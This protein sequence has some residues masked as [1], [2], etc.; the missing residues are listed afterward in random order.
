MAKVD[1]ANSDKET[2]ES[3]LGSFNVKEYLHLLWVNK[4][5]IVLSLVICV[6][7]AYYDFMRQARIYGSQAEVMLLFGNAG[8]ST[9]GGSGIQQLADMAGA[10][11]GQNVNMFNEMEII[12]SPML[13]QT[14]VQALGLNTTY[15]KEGFGHNEDLYG[16]TP[17]IVDF[18]DVPSTGS[19]S[20]TLRPGTDGYVVAS[21][22]A[23]D[24]QSKAGRQLNIPL[25]T[26]VNTP[27]GRI[28]VTPT[29]R[30]ASFTEP[31]H[32]VKRPVEE[33]ALGMSQRVTTEKK[34]IENSVVI[35]GFTDVNQ[36]RATAVVNGLV[37]AYRN[38]WAVEQSRQSEKSTEFIKERLAVI[39]KELSGID[40]N[41]SQVK[42]NAGVPDVMSA[43]GNFYGQAMSYDT[44][45][46]ES[47]T[48]LNIA[49]FLREYLEKHKGES[50]LIPSNTGANGTIEGQVAE[51][52][53]LVMKRN[54]LLANSSESNPVIAQL[55][56]DIA[57]ARSLI[58]ASLNNLIK[59]AQYE[60][61][62]AQGRGHDFSNRVAQ[63][64][65]SE[66][67]IISIERQQKVK[68]D[69]Y[70][71][72]L[73]KREE[74][75]LSSMI[76][77]DNTR[78]IRNGYETGLVTGAMRKALFAGV[79]VGLLIPLLIIFLGMQLNA[80]VTR[81]SELKDLSIPFLGEMPLTPSKR[82]R[83]F[84]LARVLHPNSRK[85]DDRELEIVVKPRSRSYINEA[86]RLIRTN[87][88]FMADTDKGSKVIMLTSFNPGSGK[89]FI[90]LNLA[91]SLALKGKKV[92][93]MDIDL[94]RA[95]LTRFAGNA[96]QGLSTYLTEK[97][98][99][100]DALIKPNNEGTGIDLLPVGAVPPNP[101]ELLLTERL[102]HLVAELR[103]KYDYIVLDCPPYDLVADTVIL[104]RVAD[105]TIFV[106][107]AGL[108]AKSMVPELE[109]IYQAGKLPRMSIILN[110]IDPRKSYYADRYGYKG[111][112]SYY[113]SED[114]DR[115]MKNELP[116]EEA[117]K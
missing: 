21:D 77:V 81:K 103:K 71:Y 106:I 109:K 4:F 74:N 94:R 84:S 36:E 43:A 8:S 60:V 52:N 58:M 14:V 49:K 25:G 31:I 105:M 10:G 7:Y 6:G 70:I 88:D 97:T 33:V 116:P 101:V 117:P 46:F 64:P 16:R 13:M 107:R 35:I 42:S 26:I 19:A 96:T 93:L 39:E 53:K 1:K 20:L 90:A 29:D 3:A 98:D 55:N 50:E 91:K 67:Q 15:S 113:I 44:R 102:D 12:R 22:F 65:K 92:I 32:V 66:K 86:F 114:K 80:K 24:G 30:M 104:S 51:Y 95:S 37:D 69:L 38:L 112:N 59:T 83:H 41:I 82:K 115:R 17:V 99:D 68:E 11:K 62:R 47:N 73:Q 78:V 34:S 89:T 76:A 23:K 79:G 5:W 61:D 111:H 72:L 85:V 100:I 56:S 63:I 87:L 110:G 108:F 9:G 57:T 54:M 18:L 40:S 75:E 28:S 2:Q 27:A 45:V 48:Q